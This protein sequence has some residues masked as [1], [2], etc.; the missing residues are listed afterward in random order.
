MSDSD[1]KLM[2]QSRSCTLGFD[3]LIPLTI[4]TSSVVLVW[5]YLGVFNFANPV[6]YSYPA[7]VQTYAIRSK[8]LLVWNT[9]SQLQSAY[10]TW[11]DA[12]ALDS[13]GE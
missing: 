13:I 1:K 8:G 2:D 11:V 3:L 4:Q 9:M 7:E 10:A 5:I 12:I 6:L